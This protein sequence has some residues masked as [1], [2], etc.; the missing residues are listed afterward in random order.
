MKRTLITLCIAT[1]IGAQA[2][3]IKI[4]GTILDEKKQPIEFVNISLGDENSKLITG[5]T[6]GSN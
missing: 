5:T 1:S 3:H 4:K 2:Q 6:S